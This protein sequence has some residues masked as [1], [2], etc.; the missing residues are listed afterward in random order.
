M[1]KNI[2]WYILIKEGG[3]NMTIKEM[4]SKGMIMLK[5]N[6]VDSPKLKA[7][8]LLKYILLQLL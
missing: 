6:N 2:K 5:G 3:V 8:L 1:Q 7:R 4:L